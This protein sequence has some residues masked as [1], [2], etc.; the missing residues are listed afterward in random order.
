MRS[1][2]TSR[3]KYGSE[4]NIASYLLDVEYLDNE[5]LTRR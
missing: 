4:A 2:V 1:S 5:I 3:A